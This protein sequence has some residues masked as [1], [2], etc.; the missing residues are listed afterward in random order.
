MEAYRVFEQVKVVVH[1]NFQLTTSL[2]AYSA[3]TANLIYPLN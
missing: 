2:L 1:E 3:T